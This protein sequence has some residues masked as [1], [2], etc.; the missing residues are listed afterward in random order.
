MTKQKRPG[1]EGNEL[2]FSAIIIAVSP[3]TKQIKLYFGLSNL[4]DTRIRPAMK[5]VGLEGLNAS[6]TAVRFKL[7]SIEKRTS[8]S[9][10]ETS[11]LTAATS[12]QEFQAIT[13]P[14]SAPKRKGALYAIILPLFSRVLLKNDEREPAALAITLMEAAT[15][16]N[17]SAAN[18]PVNTTSPHLDYVYTFLWG[19]ATDRIQA[20]DRLADTDDVKIQQ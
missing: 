17:A 1:E 5:I 2:L 15:D 14:T 20:L 6:A 10:P 19:A 9:I 16:F 11:T 3:I 18:S 7:E 12:A 4:G 13:P 8:F